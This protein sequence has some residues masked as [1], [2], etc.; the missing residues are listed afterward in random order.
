MADIIYP[1]EY[2]PMPLMDGYGFKPISPLPRTEMT[3]GRGRRQGD[4]LSTPTRPAVKWIFQ[5]DALAQVLRPF[6]RTLKDG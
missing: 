5:T 1:D 4:T 6:Q 3:S 2:L